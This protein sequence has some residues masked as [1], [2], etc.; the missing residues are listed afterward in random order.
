[1]QESKGREKELRRN[2]GGIV[3]EMVPGEYRPKQPK[4][5]FVQN[6]E[7]NLGKDQGREKKCQTE[8]RGVGQMSG[9]NKRRKRATLAI[10]EEKEPH[11][12]C[13]MHKSEHDGKKKSNKVYLKNSARTKRQMLS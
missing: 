6:P 3:T 12:K 11:V 1:V 7:S 2:S 5:L 13:K 9:R 4:K 8:K 10:T